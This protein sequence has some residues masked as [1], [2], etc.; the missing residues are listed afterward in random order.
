MAKVV[1][2]QISTCSSLQ[3]STKGNFRARGLEL[4]ES[5]E[6]SQQFFENRNIEAF[7][8]PNKKFNGQ[9]PESAGSAT[10]SFDRVVS[11]V[12]CC[13]QLISFRPLLLLLS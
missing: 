6:S 9:D 8:V 11:A 1:K 13:C 4:L 3:R 2:L 10:R 12:E 7:P 5:R